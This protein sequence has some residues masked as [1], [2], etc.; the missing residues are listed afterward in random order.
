MQ[1]LVAFSGLYPDV[2]LSALS[3]SLCYSKTS[4]P[5]RDRAKY[6]LSASFAHPYVRQ[7]RAADATV[8]AEPL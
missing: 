1:E 8:P 3:N 7:L 4:T 5:E 2:Y 6:R